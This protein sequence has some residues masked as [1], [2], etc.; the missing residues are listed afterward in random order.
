VEIAAR[1]LA[2][3]IGLLLVAWTVLSAIKTVILP[4]ASAS[5]ITRAVFLATSQLF[6]LLAPPRARYE[7]RDR[8]L[9][10]YAPISLIATLAAWL[11]LTMAGFV[12]IFIG[13]DGL[14]WSRALELSGSSLFTLGFRRPEGIASTLLAFTEAAIGLFLLALLITYL[15][16]IYSAFGRR[17]LGVTALEVRA[18]APPSARE[19]VSRYFRLERAHLLGEVWEEWERWFVDVEESHTSLPALVFFR[20]PQP[21]HAWVTA[22]GAVLDGASL[23][24]SS[25]DIPRDVQADFCIRAGYLCLRRIADFF[26]IPHDPDPA[27]DDPISVTREEWDEVVRSLAEEGVPIK[28]DLEQ[29]WRD[30]AGW[31]VN[32]DRVLLGLANLTSA[33]EAP[34]SS[35][36]SGDRTLRPRMFRS[37]LPPRGR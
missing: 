17:E 6:R 32:Y 14:G 31:R 37:T 2:T 24:L 16:S 29:A 22:A 18:G 21:D 5:T 1:I 10:S 15:P 23:V 3:A 25:V 34:W 8:V 33:P 27:P 20:S 36:R 19:M 12:L 7:H 35:D 26:R 9:A 4:R 28:H 13:V 30:F 11:A